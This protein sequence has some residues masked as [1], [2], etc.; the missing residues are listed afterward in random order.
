M[1]LL[2]YFLLIEELLHSRI[3]CAWSV[4]AGFQLVNYWVILLEKWSVVESTSPLCDCWG[5]V[6]D[7]DGCVWVH[8]YNTLYIIPFVLRQQAGCL[9]CMKDCKYLNHCNCNIV[10]NYQFPIH[11]SNASNKICYGL[12]DANVY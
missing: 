6:A 3:I 10:S 11:N 4:V 2:L 1:Q 8:I 9:E 5:C 7:A 12:I